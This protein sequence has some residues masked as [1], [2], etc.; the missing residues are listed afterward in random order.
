MEMR[1]KFGSSVLAW[2]TA[3]TVGLAMA[4]STIGFGSRTTDPANDGKL[5]QA[6]E[7][8]ER[9]EIAGVENAFRLSP[10]LYSG[11]QPEGTGALSALKG[12][13]IK[14]IISVDGSGPGPRTLAVSAS[15]MSISRSATTASPESRPCASSRRSRRSRGRFSSIVTTASTGGPR[16]PLCVAS[17]PKAGPRSRP[18][19]G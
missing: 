13:G 14:T 10:R 17:P 6:T 2:C 5:R 12:L 9:V 19:P 16:L 8:P 1:P 11:G 7:T 18:W 15:A 3:F 4:A